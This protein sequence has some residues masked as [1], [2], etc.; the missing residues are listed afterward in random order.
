MN[1]NQINANFLYNFSPVSH[2]IKIPIRLNIRP[3]YDP[4]TLQRIVRIEL[5][6]KLLSLKHKVPMPPVILDT[7]LT[8]MECIK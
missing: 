4:Y 1:E 2:S 7:G 5:Y 8:Y 6:G 3:G